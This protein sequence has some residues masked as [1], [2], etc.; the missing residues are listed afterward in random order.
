MDRAYC[1]SLKREVTAKE[2]V[3]L[4]RQNVITKKDDFACLDAS[5]RARY[6][7]A[8]LGRKTYK[9]D[10]Y[11]KTAHRSERHFPGCSFEPKYV[12]P[13]QNILG[14]GR[15]ERS[16][17]ADTTEVV[18]EAK[19]RKGYFG[20]PVRTRKFPADE[21]V[22]LR[23]V[24]N[25]PSGVSSGVANPKC[26][27]IETLLNGGWSLCR[28]LVIDGNSGTIK[29]AFV[30]VD[31]QSPDVFRRFIY[32]GLAVNIDICEKYTYFKFGR[33]FSAPHNGAPVIVRLLG[34]AVSESV[35]QT[36][37]YYRALLERLL[38]VAKVV[39]KRPENQFFLY[40]FG[41]P[42]YDELDGV[43]NIDIESLDHIYMEGRCHRSELIANIY[44]DP[45][46]NDHYFV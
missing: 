17:I 27:S 12:V 11:F 16:F 14:K 40:A 8:N 28:G 26:Y 35:S 1:I 43:W 38:A 45:E 32:C 5:C 42:K 10:H 21:I 3:D 39:S 22:S 20:V 36:R 13:T 46:L 4:Y 2:V 30:P 44:S 7:C 31:N 18:F 23:Y 9:V 41:V 33:C 6:V 29:S 19:R 25:R 37:A 34:S 15:R 24:S